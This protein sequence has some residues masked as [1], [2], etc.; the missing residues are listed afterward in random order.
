MT[1]LTR[2]V[3]LLTPLGSLLRYVLPGEQLKRLI[4]CLYKFFEKLFCPL[5]L[6]RVASGII[7]SVDAIS[8]DRLLPQNPRIRG[9]GRTLP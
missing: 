5:S 6:C 7:R 1:A 9:A 8:H 4:F 2:S 3:L